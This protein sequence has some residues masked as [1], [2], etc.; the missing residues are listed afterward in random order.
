M[1]GFIMILITL[2]K[3]TSEIS[4]YNI[5]KNGLYRSQLPSEKMIKEDNRIASYDNY[6]ALDVGNYVIIPKGTIIIPA[7]DVQ[8]HIGCL[9]YYNT[10]FIFKN[11]IYSRIPHDTPITYNGEKNKINHMNIFT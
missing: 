3:S 9:I 8:L 10:P 5:I 4:F 11:G 2:I 6:E 7:N 1:Y